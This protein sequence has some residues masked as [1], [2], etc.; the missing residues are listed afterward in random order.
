[1]QFLVSSSSNCF[2]NSNR[3]AM[4]SL[5]DKLSSCVIGISF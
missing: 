5:L 1:L 4:V 3:E 2:T